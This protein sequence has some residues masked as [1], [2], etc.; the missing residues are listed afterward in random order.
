M[1]D[2]ILHGSINFVELASSS[3][4][5]PAL[6][7]ACLILEQ[8]WNSV[9][10]VKVNKSVSHAVHLLSLLVPGDARHFS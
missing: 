8:I 9:E 6:P 10:Q 5:L 4:I 2:V 7:A 1:L 3:G